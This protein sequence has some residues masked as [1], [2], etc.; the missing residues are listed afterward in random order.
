ME[1]FLVLKCG[2]WKLFNQWEFIGINWTLIQPNCLQ[3]KKMFVLSQVNNLFDAEVMKVRNLWGHHWWYSVRVCCDPFLS[4]RTRLN[5]HTISIISFFNRG[6]SSSHRSNKFWFFPQ[7]YL[8]SLLMIKK[9]PG[10]FLFI[11]IKLTHKKFPSFK[12][13]RILT[14]YYYWSL[15]FVSFSALSELNRTFCSWKS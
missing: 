2:K 13:N 10:L 4:S 9:N 6:C 14:F 3:T 12:M 8:K 7:L 11:P 15:K 5:N 1:Y